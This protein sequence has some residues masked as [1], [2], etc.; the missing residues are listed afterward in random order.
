M[1]LGFNLGDPALIVTWVGVV[2]VSILVH[3]LGHAFAL[4]AFGQSSSIV[5]H[6]FGG[7][8]LSQ[9]RLRRVESIIVSLAGPLTA[10]ALL[11]IPAV[12]LDGRIGDDLYLDWIIGG[13]DFG[14]YPVLEFAVYVNIWWSLANL[15]P[16]RP[17]DGG[18]VM[19]EIIGIDKARIASVVVAA[20]AAVYAFTQFTGLRFVAF[21][22]AFLAFI[23]FSEYRRSTRGERAPSAFDVDA[24]APA[25]GG[26]V[27][28]GH[29]VGPAAQPKRTATSPTVVNLTG[30]LDADSAETFAW[31]MLRSGDV[32]AAAAVLRR[33]TGPVGPFVT[34]TLAVAS[35]DGTDSLRRAYLEHPSGPSNLV[36]ALVLVRSGEAQTFCRDLIAAGDAGIDAVATIQTH[37]HYAERFSDAAAVGSTRY[38]WAGRAKAQVAFDVACSH[39]RAGSLDAAFEWLDR[40]VTDGFMAP[41]LLDGEDDLQSLRT[42]P[43]WAAL[44]TRL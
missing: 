40:A 18:N 42:D 21:F 20:A 29:N 38:A 43:R 30:G 32:N 35:G 13:G 39:A 14:W 34:P 26:G 16:I 8:T 28:P 33:S 31:N 6:G 44:R 12:V 19:T 17:L 2:G 25:G 37:L 36:P 15:L 23:N 9:R 4:K 5:L 3:E 1:L 27:L 24:P 41:R 11:G 10:L 22:A 7:L